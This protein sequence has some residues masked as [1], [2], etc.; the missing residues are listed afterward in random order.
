[1]PL[2]IMIIMIFFF[3]KCFVKIQ[4]LRERDYYS[5]CFE[6]LS[7]YLGEQIII[8]VEHVSILRL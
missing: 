5:M 6:I 3:F 7:V 4:F 8:S 2:E 1:M